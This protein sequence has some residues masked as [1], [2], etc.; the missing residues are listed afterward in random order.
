MSKADHCLQRPVPTEIHMKKMQQGFTLIELMIVVAIIGIL[1]AIAIPAYQDYII[2]TQVSEG[3]NLIDG[4]KTSIA[5]F[6]NNYG[7]LPPNN[8]SAGLATSASIRGKYV[9]TVN[10]ATGVV[11]AIFSNTGT[12][13]SNSA[14]AGSRLTYSAIPTSGGGTMNWSCKSTVATTPTNIANKYLPTVCR[15]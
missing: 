11:T 3:S 13:Q 15:S 5:D 9:S 4:T 14:I 6:Y 7:R 10:N 12:T 8:S 1:A 2:R